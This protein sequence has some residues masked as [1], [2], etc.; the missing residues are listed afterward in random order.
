MKDKYGL[1]GNPLGHSFSQGFFTEKFEREGIDAEYLKY[2]LPAISDFPPIIASNPELKG[3]N[4]TIPYKEQIIPFLDELDENTKEI[5]AVNVVK[6]LK[7]S[8]KTRLKGY[9]S[10]M[11]GFQNSIAPLLQERHKK[12][13]V[14]GTGGASKAVVQGLKNLGI[15]TQLVS[16][17]KRDN[18]ISYNDLD[19][20]TLEEYT[21]IVNASPVG[22]FPHVE[23]FPQI[24]YH[25]LTSKHLLYDLVYNPAETT[26]LKKG[27]QYN[28]QTKNGA[29]MLTLQAIKAWEIWNS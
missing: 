25:Y 6:V 26:F 29:E 5:G 27:K 7:E 22:T 10:D 21:I 20:K 23:Q 2:E 9:N 16:R 12:A 13:L 19:K 1:I 28:A 8:G 3:L 18:F 17:S 11:Y 14:L 4:V 24:P 15:E